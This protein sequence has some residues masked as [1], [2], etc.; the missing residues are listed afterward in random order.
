[1]FAYNGFLL[2]HFRTGRTFFQYRE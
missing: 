1:M 2:D